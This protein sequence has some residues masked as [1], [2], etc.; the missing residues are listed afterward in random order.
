MGNFSAARSALAPSDHEVAL[1][2]ALQRLGPEGVASAGGREVASCSV[3][4]GG[5]TNTSYRVDTAGGAVVIRLPGIATNGL[6]QREAEGHNSRAM[7]QLGIDV[8]LL[9]FDA[10][11]GIKITRYLKGAEPPSAEELRDPACLTEL[12]A[13]LRTVHSSGAEFQ[14]AFNPQRSGEH[15]QA[16]LAAQGQPLPPEFPAA[17]T[18]LAGCRE[19]LSQAPQRQVPCHQD[20]Y[21]ENWLRAGCRLWLLDWEHSG[22]GEALYDLADL[23]VQTGFTRREDE[24]LLQ[25]YFEIATIPGAMAERFWLQQQVSRLTWGLW[26]LTRAS[27]GYAQPGHRAAGVRKIDAARDELGLL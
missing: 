21:R 22:P 1:R 27:L 25:H 6:L 13:L 18:A 7:S 12:C 24:R 14:S 9:H 20:L 2:A 16:L 3:R 19:K 23:S 17:L 15:F 10:A 26:A 4:L 8:P 5:I 11:G